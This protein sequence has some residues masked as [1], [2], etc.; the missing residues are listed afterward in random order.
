MNAHLENGKVYPEI[1][2]AHPEHQNA[3][4]EDRSTRPEAFTAHLE[5]QNV[6]PKS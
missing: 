3:H 1:I 6:H 2:N 4:F 5:T